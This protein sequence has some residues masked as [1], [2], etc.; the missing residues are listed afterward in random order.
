MHDPKTRRTVAAT[1]TVLSCALALAFAPVSQ[2]AAAPASVAQDAGDAVPAAGPVTIEDLMLLRRVSSID[3]SL[4]GRRA[5]MAVSGPEW[6]E[7]GPTELPS[8]STAAGYASHLHLI[9]VDAASGSATVRRLTGGRGASD[10]SP[11]IDP[12][13]RVVAFLRRGATDPWWDGSAD[14][15]GPAGDHPSMGAQVWI[16]PLDGGEAR[17]LTW[18]RRGCRRISWSPD[19]TQ[20]LLTVTRPVDAIAGVP[21]WATTRPG[22]SDQQRP[23]QGDGTD[24]AGPGDSR[25]AMRDWLDAGEAD[26]DP[27]ATTRVNFQGETGPAG[28]I[29]I[30]Q[31]A[32]VPIDV[33]ALVRGDG[34]ASRRRQGIASM[35]VNGGVQWPMS[36]FREGRSPSWSPDGKT[37]YVSTPVDPGQHPDEPRE[38]GIASVPV[39]G[40]PVSMRVSVDGW[41]FDRPVRRD[42]RRIAFTG[43][44]T[45]FPADRQS[46]L[47]VARIADD[48][49]ALTSAAD[50]QWLTDEG[51]F[52]RSIR[53]FDWDGTSAMFT[54]AF[55]GGFPL[56]S[57]GFGMLRPSIVVGDRDGRPVGVH[58]FNRGG[59][60][61]MWAET[62]AHNPCIVR[63][64]IGNREI[65]V[66]DLNPWV[67]D[68]VV[69]LPEFR[70]VERP[71]GTA[72]D[73]WVMRPAK[74]L[75]GRAPI[76]LQIH[77][78][79]SAMWGPGEVTMWHEFQVLCGWGYGVVYANPRGSGGYGFAFQHAN[80]QDWGEGPGGDVLAALDEVVN[81][82][83]V[84]RDRLFVTGGSYGG[85]LVAWIVGNDQRF[86]AAVAQRGVYHLSTFYGEGNAW[87]LLEAEMGG[88]PW[89]DRLEAVLRRESP[90]T[91]VDR[92]RTPLLIMHGDNDLR[93]GVSQSE[94]LYRALA[95][96]G[97]PVEY[98]RYPDTSHG[99]SRT[100]PP[101][102]R[103]DRLARI[104]EFFERHA[105]R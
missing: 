73:A 102:R 62:S 104:V 29:S 85:Y 74:E 10:S 105:G 66:V 46:H 25:S 67:A 89:E 17:Q 24:A 76:V 96:L 31:P 88:K 16:M 72:V 95:D 60:T 2:G 14:P 30:P 23:G 42:D 18:F 84:D 13:G 59:G 101:K 9:D 100:G 22:R 91:Y 47:A 37:L 26:G 35:S 87:R 52:D 51:G 53:A 64:R 40:G 77:G 28:P 20:L 98:V 92:I 61:I 103:M 38:W 71:D 41:T 58:A 3:V 97:R 65:E 1:V 81:D 15:G 82:D 49:P 63:A 44:Q 75:A 78:G 4:D 54:A 34:P 55:G 69:S 36:G 33:D 80:T 27:R 70:P 94:M 43:S 32:I 83:W 45:D 11:E 8:R 39:D 19:G 86:S 21:P 48:G 93:T 79:P 12:S 90:F 57:T 5:V 99:L 7:L 56:C 68:R 6:R 50:L